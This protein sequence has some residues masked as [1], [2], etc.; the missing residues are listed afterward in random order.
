MIKEKDWCCPKCKTQLVSG[1]ARKYETLIEHIECSNDPLPERETYVCS[2][3]NCEL[4][5]A[6]FWDFYGDIYCK[7][8][9]FYSKNKI[10]IDDRK[11]FKNCGVYPI[12]SYQYEEEQKTIKKRNNFL[13]PIF[14]KIKRWY[15]WKVKNKLSNKSIHLRR[16][17]NPLYSNYRDKQSKWKF[18]LAQWLGDINPFSR[19]Y[20]QINWMIKFN[21][22]EK[23]LFSNWAYHPYPWI[24]YYTRHILKKQGFEYRW[25]RIVKNNKKQQNLF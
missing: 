16:Q 9:S 19:V 20:K 8:D 25:N 21:M 1:E 2:N 3:E 11:T 17:H 5:G 15:C 22:D 4:N 12:G 24:R 6:V 14:H 7:E 13:W 23:M 10:E 18:V